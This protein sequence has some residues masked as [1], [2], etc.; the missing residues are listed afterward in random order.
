MFDSLIQSI[1]YYSTETR[2]TTQVI[3]KEIDARNKKKYSSSFLFI[4]IL[5]FLLQNTEITT[6]LQTHPDE[7]LSDLDFADD[8]LLLD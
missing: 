2:G 1:I 5:D 8:T 3:T 7:F 6:G 4:I